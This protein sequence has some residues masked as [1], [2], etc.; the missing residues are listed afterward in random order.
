MSY[1]AFNSST[2]LFISCRVFQPY[3]IAL[4]SFHNFSSFL[5]AFFHLFLYNIPNFPFCYFL[6]SRGI[7][8]ILYKHFYFCTKDKKT[9]RQISKNMPTFKLL[10]AD[11]FRNKAIIYTRQK[12]TAGRCHQT[13][14]KPTGYDK[15]SPR[16]NPDIHCIRWNK[17]ISFV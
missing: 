11:V 17:E 14:D 15:K 4:P 12:I 16:S 9:S 13:A 3:S 7:A 6:Y 1:L 8:N 5:R 10:S 2:L